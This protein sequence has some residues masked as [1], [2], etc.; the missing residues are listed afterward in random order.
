MELGATDPRTEVLV[1]QALSIDDEDDHGYWA[2]VTALQSRGEIETFAIMSDLCS[3]GSPARQRL[4]LNVLAQ[5]GFESGRPFLEQS[6]PIVTG[7]S[8]PD[9]HDSVLV[10]AVSALGHLHDV[11]GL[12]SVLA[13][14][15]H[16]NQQVRFAVA[17]C[18]P[19]VAGDPADSRAV[20]ALIRLS[21]DE[22]SDVRDW[23]T[24][25]IGSL[26]EVDDDDVRQALMARIDDSDGDTAGEALVGLAA[27]RDNRIFNRIN[28]QL[29]DLGVGNLIVEAA[30]KLAD[31]RLLPALYRLRDEGWA[32]DDPRGQWLQEA[33]AACERGSPAEN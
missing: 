33:I 22:A 15:D 6:L 3:S 7:L 12:N 23:A 26:L 9:V 5:L 2:V 24:F 31:V 17:T 13:F 1:E 25:G 14:A 29:G 32:H 27:R 21:I 19:F 20:E 11:R 8:R 28:D 18:L 4:G 16:D 10:A 30:A